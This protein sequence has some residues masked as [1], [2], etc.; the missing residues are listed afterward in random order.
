MLRLVIEDDG[1]GFDPDAAEG[2]DA[3]QGIRQVRPRLGL[4][5][6]QERLALINGS[7]SIESAP[8]AGTTLFIKIPAN[9]GNGW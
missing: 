7:M 5:G 6:I 4:S 8:G 9:A 3:D 2:T 1:V